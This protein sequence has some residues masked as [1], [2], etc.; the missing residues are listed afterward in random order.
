[1]GWR[2]GVTIASSGLSDFPCARPASLSDTNL[3]W[4]WWSNWWLEGE[5]KDDHLI[6]TGPAAWLTTPEEP[7]PVSPVSIPSL[8]F[9]L[10]SPENINE[11][12]SA[13][14]NIAMW[15]RL[16]LPL[17]Y[18]LCPSH[19]RPCLGD[20]GLVICLEN[21]GW[22]TS[23][24]SLIMADLSVL[25]F[26]LVLFYECLPPVDVSFRYSLDTREEWHSTVPGSSLSIY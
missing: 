8:S 24:K 23:C 13:I 5:N 1:M 22:S 18:P 26:S 15:S 2:G 14:A 16:V 17:P 10:S 7:W 4:W 6:T 3:W 25:I 20:Q 9:P 19:H 11:I 12:A 21:T